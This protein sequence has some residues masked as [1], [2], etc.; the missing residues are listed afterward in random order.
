MPRLARDL[1]RLEINHKL[2]SDNDLRAANVAAD[3][4][5][6]RLSQ[7][8]W[9]S[10]ESCPAAALPVWQA[11]LCLAIL[12]RGQAPASL[13]LEVGREGGERLVVMVGHVTLFELAESDAD[14]LAKDLQPHLF[15]RRY[16]SGY[17]SRFTSTPRQVQNTTSQPRS[18]KIFSKS[19]AKPMEI[20]DGFL[21][22]VTICKE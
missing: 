11:T 3:L 13:G 10:F 17:S 4:G 9:L 6:S 2:L 8:R 12:P 18:R 5:L 15:S 7:V 20:A 1:P 22:L 14:F 19:L 21:K 16:H